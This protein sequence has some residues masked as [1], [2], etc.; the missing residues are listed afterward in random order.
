[1]AEEGAPTRI[2]IFVDFW[3]Y[4]LNMQNHDPTFQTDWFTMPWALADCARECLRVTSGQARYEGIF[5]A[6]SFDQYSDSDVRL[7]N[8]AQNTLIKAPGS[9]IDFK[10][11]QKTS[12]G[13]RC[14]GNLHHE[15]KN[16]PD[17]GASM[18]GTREK[19]VDTQIVTEMLRCA[20]EDMYDVGVLVSEDRDFVPAVSHLASRGFKFIHARFPDRGFELRK[21]CWGEINLVEAKNKFQRLA[22]PKV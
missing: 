7:R 10:P 15:V 5:I 20:W 14:I 16:C 9:R 12:S 11:R 13:P 21:Y 4:T 19:G 18:L 1:M 2:M 8:W 17:C 22:N 6:G 3:N